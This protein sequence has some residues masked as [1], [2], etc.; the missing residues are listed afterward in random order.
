[1]NRKLRRPVALPGRANAYMEYSGS[2]TF[3]HLPLVFEDPRDLRPR[4]PS[5]RMLRLT[6]Y[7]SLGEPAAQAR[8]RGFRLCA[9][10]TL[11]SDDN[12]LAATRV[13]G[14]WLIGRRSFRRF[15]CAGPVMVI[16][17][18]TAAHPISLGSFRL[19][20]AGAAL[21]WGD[22][23]LL[24]PRVPSWCAGDEDVHEVSLVDVSSRSP[25]GI[26]S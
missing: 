10:A 8:A 5:R 16:V 3:A 14:S 26:H 1:M 24:Q 7:A 25:G 23:E 13:N 20:R 6:F 2:V 21:I 17:R 12:S 4:G 22:G 19:V 9:D 15:D 18:R 11:R